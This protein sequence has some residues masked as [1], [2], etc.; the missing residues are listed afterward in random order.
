MES[1]FK[2]PNT[3]YK[4]RIVLQLKLLQIIKIKPFFTLCEEY[5]EKKQSEGFGL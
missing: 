5:A 1:R 4:Q 3:S 2:L